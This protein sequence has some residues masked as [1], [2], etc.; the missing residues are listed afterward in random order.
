[1]YEDSQYESVIHPLRITY[2]YRL[3]DT[4]TNMCRSNN[5]TVNPRLSE[6]GVAG[7]EY[8]CTDDDVY[9]PEWKTL[10]E[11]TADWMADFLTLFI[12]NDNTTEPFTIRPNDLN[13]DL[14]SNGYNVSGVDAS[15][16]WSYESTDLVIFMS[17]HKC[18]MGVAGYAGCYDFDDDERCIVGYFNWCPS[19]IDIENKD[20]PTIKQQDRYLFVHETGHVLGCCDADDFKTFTQE[21]AV[22]EV[23]VFT[24]SDASVQKRVKIVKTPKI[25]ETLREQTGCEDLAGAE[26][27]DV[28]LGV[29]AHF[30]ARAFGGEVMAYGLLS[31]EPYLSDITLAYL[32]DSGHYVA[33]RTYAVGC[34]R[35]GTTGCTNFSYE[36]GGRFMEASAT[37]YTESYLSSL[38]AGDDV[39]EPESVDVKSPGY[40]RWGRGQGCEFFREKPSDDT[41]GSKYL[42]SNNLQGGCTPDN[43]MSARCYIQ[44]WQ[45]VADPVSCVGTCG[46]T[47]TNANPGEVPPW[48]RFESLLG[49]CSGGSCPAGYSDSMDFVPV[50]LGYWNCLD[51]Q[52]ATTTFMDGYSNQTVVQDDTFDALATELE[53]FGGQSHCENCRCFES[54]LREVGSIKSLDYSSYGLCYISNCFRPDYL[55]VGVRSRDGG[56]EW[57]GC[58]RGGGS[59]YI[60]GFTGSITCPQALTFCAYEDISGYYYGETDMLLAW[61]FFGVVFGVPSLLLFYCCCCPEHAKPCVIRCK[62]C[63]GVALTRDERIQVARKL[64]RSRVKRSNNMTHRIH[65]FEERLL[66]RGGSTLHYIPHQD[67]HNHNPNTLTA[68]EKEWAQKQVHKNRATGKYTLVARLAD[69]PIAKEYKGRL[70][71]TEGEVMDIALTIKEK[72]P[73]VSGLAGAATFVLAKI[74]SKTDKLLEHYSELE[75]EKKSGW[76]AYILHTNNTIWSLFALFLITMAIGTA[77]EFGVWKDSINAAPFLYMTGILITV[78]ACMGSIGSSTNK[79]TLTLLCYFYVCLTSLIYVILLVIAF[80]LYNDYFND[81]IDSEWYKVRQFFPSSYASLD[82]DDALDEFND[83]TAGYGSIGLIVLGAYTVLSLLSG[84]ICSVKIMKLDSIV[85]NIFIGMN[86]FLLTL[87]VFSLVIGVAVLRSAVLLP[88]PVICITLSVILILL[89]IFGLYND[90]HLSCQTVSTHIARHRF[91]FKVYAVMAAILSFFFVAGGI[92]FLSSKSVIEDEIDG[93]TESEIADLADSLEQSGS[94]EQMKDFIVATMLLM[95]VM[96]M[97]DGAVLGL[98][99]PL[100]IYM[101]KLHQKRQHALSE[102]EKDANYARKNGVLKYLPADGL[103]IIPAFAPYREKIRRARKKNE[104]REEAA[105][106]RDVEMANVRRPSNMEPRA[107]PRRQS[108]NVT[109]L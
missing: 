13:F 64:A 5:Q 63:C 28:P 83:D 4:D 85:L 11:E 15:T 22:E 107:P 103:S 39:F 69:L 56:I 31:S 26:L 70:F 91:L 43:R 14:S 54:T 109:S 59:L 76:Y 40:L 65:A 94:Q 100:I 18:P 38:F 29:G 92:G 20:D 6:R 2:D 3:L 97:V 61:I 55:Q 71:E 21:Q 104:M 8:E 82:R 16:E 19:Q 98:Q 58:P 62:L 10:M 7:T 1:M 77:F 48:G 89:A 46:D 79:P 57:Y 45:S 81:K 27:E 102:Y 30:E 32:E 25:V 34:D 87:A 24:A 53:L 101:D 41:W 36:G 42:C 35:Y 47:N 51:R 90:I 93:L 33:N 105:Q 78:F 106:L 9:Q 74:D 23:T 67:L 73:R 66:E 95:G 84:V 52:P 12:Y 108:K 44:S 17:L 72:D 75:F 60:P 99:V 49:G 88:F 96:M 37:D 86:L 50:R 80:F 68:E